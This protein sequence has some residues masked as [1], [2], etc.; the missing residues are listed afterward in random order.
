MHATLRQA[1]SVLQ[2]AGLVAGGVRCSASMRAA[3]PSDMP[4]GRQLH[5]LADMCQ[6]RHMSICS[7]FS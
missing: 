3:Q 1:S 4:V 2:G 5:R 7:L 6:H